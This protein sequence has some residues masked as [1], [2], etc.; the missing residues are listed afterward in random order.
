[1]W[2][3]EMNRVLFT[4]HNVLYNLGPVWYGLAFSF[5]LFEQAVDGGTRYAEPDGRLVYVPL[6]DGISLQYGAL[7]QLLKR[8]DLFW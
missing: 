5:I 2:S 1:M 3:S 6:T 4:L 8:Q 7:L